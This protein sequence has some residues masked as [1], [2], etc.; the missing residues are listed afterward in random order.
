MKLLRVNIAGAPE[1]PAILDDDGTIRDL[2][3]EIT[4]INGDTL[5][6]DTLDKLRSLDLSRL[7]EITG[8]VRI[9]APVGNVGKIIGIGLN[10]SDHA[11]ETGMAVPTEPIMFLKAT[12]AICGPNDDVLIPRNSNKTDWEVEL[13]IVIGKRANYVSEQDAMQYVAGYCIMNDISEREFQ[14]ERGTQWSKGKSA[15]TFA[16]IGPWLVT[17]DEIP[18]PQNLNMW[19]EID[20]HLYQNGCTKTMVFHVPYLVHYISQFTTLMAGDIITTGT[21]PGVGMGQKPNPIYLKA[22]QTMTLGI[23]GLGTQQQF[24]KDA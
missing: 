14:M 10:Y 4:D 1:K 22:G 6:D 15:D 18:D 21:P 17:R 19:L 11:A 7:P 24:T 13:A 12:S 3:G 5:G 16:P 20:G 2:S 8:D 9:G 23:D